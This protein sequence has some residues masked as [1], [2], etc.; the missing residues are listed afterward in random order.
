MPTSAPISLIDQI[1]P[2][3]DCNEVHERLYPASPEAVWTAL[4]TTPINEVRLAGGLMAIRNIPKY[5]T[6]QAPL[7]GAPAIPALDA[8]QR[9][10]F[11]ALGEVPLHEIALGAIGKFWKLAGNTPVRVA[12]RVAFMQFTQP[13][14]ARAVMNFRLVPEVGGARLITE[15]RILGT[16]PASSRAFKRYWFVIRLP[17]GAIRRSWLAAIARNCV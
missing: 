13:G 16:D 15:T 9:A 4:K 17:S 3:Y 11:V 5:L 6:G 8:L 2:L 10:G 1:L 12:D 7:L 14:F